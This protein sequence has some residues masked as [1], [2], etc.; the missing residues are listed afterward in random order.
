M[1]YAIVLEMFLPFENGGLR[2]A[3]VSHQLNTWV[4]DAVS[5]SAAL[6]IRARGDRL[7]EGARCY[8]KYTILTTAVDRNPASL[9]ISRIR[10]ILV[11]P[12][13]GIIRPRR[14]IRAL[15][16]VFSRIVPEIVE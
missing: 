5:I 7:A 8:E 16:N 9:Y 12:T 15:K 6:V 4:T 1:A 14:N 13:C 11:D 2:C 3:L 10:A